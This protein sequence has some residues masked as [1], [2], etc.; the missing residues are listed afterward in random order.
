VP[1]GQSTKYC[2][3]V[4]DFAETQV[5]ITDPLC[6][7]PPRTPHYFVGMGKSHFTLGAKNSPKRKNRVGEGSG[8]K[9]SALIA[10]NRHA[11]RTFSLWPNKCSDVLSQIEVL[12]LGYNV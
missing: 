5:A 8:K 11:G 12:A 2:H 4:Q 6:V 10:K 3:Q 9:M 1:T 7:R